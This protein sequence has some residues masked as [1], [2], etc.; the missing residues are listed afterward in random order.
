M[1]DFAEAVGCAVRVAREYGVRVDEP[2][3]LHDS[4][5]LRVHLWPAPVVARIPGL[6]ALGRPRPVEALAREVDVVSFLAG[7]G[8]PVVPVSDW[9]PSGPHERDGVAITFWTYVDHDP[10][11]RLKPG[12]VGRALAD[13]H[14]ALRD[15]P[16]ELPYLGPVLDETAHLLD[17]FDST[18]RFDAWAQSELREAHTR[19]E[20]ELRTPGVGKARAC[21]PNGDANA[22]S[23]RETQ[24]TDELR[25]P[26]GWEAHGPGGWQ[27]REV[28]AGRGWGLGVQALHGDAHPGNL[29]VTPGGLLWTDFEETCAGPVGW[30]LA[31]L[32]RTSRLDGRQAL[33]E[34]GV[35]PDDPGLKVMAEARD[36]QATLWTMAKAI[37]FPDHLARAE[38]VLDE[39]RGGV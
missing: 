23:G 1:I 24:D 3:V 15:Y 19:L 39:W 20:A 31:C 9:L 32:R 35:D 14:L 2:V 4:Y 34:Y 37:R 30:D 12:E 29:L 27:E 25:A 22:W 33:R 13:L 7:K 11:Q 26:D 18:E 36:L 6:T 21:E 16:G 28:V 17:L 10:S 8:A 5:N 38:A